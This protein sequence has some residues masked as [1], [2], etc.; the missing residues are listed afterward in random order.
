[1]P[2]TPTIP[3]VVETVRGVLIDLTEVPGRLAAL[4]PQDAEATARILER[5]SEEITEAAM[6]LRAFATPPGVTGL[7]VPG[8][9]RNQDG[10]P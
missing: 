3:Q 8:G 1:M 2:V 10:T 4:H 9:D 5:L 7:P 6:M